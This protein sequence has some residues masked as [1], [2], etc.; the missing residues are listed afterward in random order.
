MTKI[1]DI[2][3]LKEFFL[4]LGKNPDTTILFNVSHFNYI[5]VHQGFDSIKP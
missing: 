5:G 2:I 4:D 1:S 3:T